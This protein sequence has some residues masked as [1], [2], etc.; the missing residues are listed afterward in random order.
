[1]LLAYLV[2]LFN[3]RENVQSTG[4]PKGYLKCNMKI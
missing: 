4:L 2:F 1:M 3:H